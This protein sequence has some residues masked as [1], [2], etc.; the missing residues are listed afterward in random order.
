MT[1]TLLYF[2]RFPDFTTDYEKRHYKKITGATA[3]YCM[4]QIDYF[5]LDHDVCKYTHAEIW[6]IED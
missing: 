3:V 4:K 2:E 5:R 1:V 6:D